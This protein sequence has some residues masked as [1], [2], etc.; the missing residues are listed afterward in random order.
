NP[1][2]LA[3]VNSQVAAFLRFG[4]WDNAFRAQGNFKRSDNERDDFVGADSRRFYIRVRHPSRAGEQTV[5]A[6]WFTMD[7][8]PGQRNVDT[9]SGDKTITLLERSPGIFT[10]KALIL[11]CDDFDAGIKD[12]VIPPS[13]GDPGGSFPLTTNRKKRGES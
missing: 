11:A 5:Q 12:I 10:S 1:K 7:G 13:P 8:F 4:L 2:F 3:D 6:D 9:G